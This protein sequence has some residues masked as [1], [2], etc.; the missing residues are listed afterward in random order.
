[1]RSP[2][3]LSKIIDRYDLTSTEGVRDLEREIRKSWSIREIQMFSS[4]KLFCEVIAQDRDARGRE[5]ELWRFGRSGAV[6]RSY[7]QYQALE[8]LWDHLLRT[9]C[10]YLGAAAM[11]GMLNARIRG[12]YLFADEGDGVT[13]YDMTLLQLIRQVPIEYA[14]RLDV[15]T[16]IEHLQQ[17][18]D[19][20]DR[21]VTNP[22]PGKNDYQVSAVEMSKIL[23]RLG[24]GRSARTIQ[25]WEK[26]LNTNGRIGTKPPM[27]YDLYTRLTVQTATAWAQDFAAH[28]KAKLRTK[29]SLRAC[30]L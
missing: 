17:T 9:S 14:K 4:F 20:I 1:M 8:R 11:L 2:E 13:L 16:K 26:Y 18:T 15:A 24:T 22:T 27:G 5:R 21:K 19:D 25:L 10:V 28:E 7:A 23:S 6:C 12:G 30:G 3:E 29:V